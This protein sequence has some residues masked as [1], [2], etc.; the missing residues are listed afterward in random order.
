MNNSGI[1]ILTWIVIA[2]SLIVS[3]YIGAKVAEGS[4]FNLVLCFALVAGIF[5]A[6]F[7]NKYW[8]FI[9]LAIASFAVRIQ[10]MGPALDPEHLA[11]LLAAGFIL[12]N[13]WKKVTPT[14]SEKLVSKAN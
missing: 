5:Y 12:S 14:P 1:K 11:T 9:S 2:T 7:I 13:F 10:P 6:L 3:L 4:Y 8:I